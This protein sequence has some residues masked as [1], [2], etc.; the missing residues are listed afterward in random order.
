M[1]GM[2]SSSASS[3]LQTKNEK[4]LKLAINPFFSGT[5]PVFSTQYHT[6][7]EE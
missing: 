3:S 4:K 1:H 7:P 2:V 5:I 6:G